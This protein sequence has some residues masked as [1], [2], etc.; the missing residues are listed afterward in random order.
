MTLMNQ[1]SHGNFVQYVQTSPNL[2]SF[3]VSAPDTN[4]YLGV[5][6]SSDGSMVGSSAIVG[7]VSATDGVAVVKQYYLGGRVPSQ[8]VPDQG[9]LQ[10]NSSNI[11]SQSSRLYM[12]FQLI[13]NNSQPSSR[14][15]YAIGRPGSLPSSQTYTLTEHLDKVSTTLNYV[16]GKYMTFCFILCVENRK[17]IILLYSMCI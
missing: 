9:S 12:A 7:W 13:V 15:L 10:V 5:G 2:W 11:A 17:L 6:F 14:L 3:V 4:S 1:S 8:V 16:T